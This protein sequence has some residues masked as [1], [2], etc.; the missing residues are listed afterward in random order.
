[1]I[2]ILDCHYVGER[3]PE[4]PHGYD[5]IHIG[6]RFNLDLAIAL[7]IRAVPHCR[8]T[9][10]FHRPQSVGASMALKLAGVIESRA[11][12][13]IETHCNYAE[14][15]EVR[16]W[17]VIHG[18]GDALG[19][20]VSGRIAEAWSRTV[21]DERLGSGCPVVVRDDLYLAR[22]LPDRGVAFVLPELGNLEVIK[23]RRVL[24]ERGGLWWRLVEGCASALEVMQ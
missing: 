18:P 10:D 23:I 3:R 14:S 20:E 17:C 5:E 8:V 11:G 21:V 6:R 24:H 15:V 2:A 12:L 16:G 13:A 4:N 22:E 1:M 9:V 7:G 19:A